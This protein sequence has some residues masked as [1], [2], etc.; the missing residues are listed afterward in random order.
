MTEN[1][2]INEHCAYSYKVS[3]MFDDG[4]H[5]R[6]KI[7]FVLLATEQTIED[8]M[9]TLRPDGVGIHFTRAWI[10]DGITVDT[11]SRH[12]ND[13]AR[14]AST[15]LPDGSLDV[16]CYGCTSGSLV[17]GEERVARELNRGAPKAHATSLI[18]AA[19]A[20]LRALS[21]VR[22]AVATPYLD[23]INDQERIYLEEAGFEVTSIQG[24]QLEKDSDMIRVRPD[25][26]AELARTVDTAE[27]EAVFISCGA[28]RSLDIVD[29]LEQTLGK[30]VICSN[31][32]MMWH[33]LRLVGI[34][35]PI[36]GYGMLLRDL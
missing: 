23:E 1:E 15:L 17:I 19:I 11:L 31:Q 16:I 29:A 35:D 21:V 30:P 7:G 6:A 34:T 14:A 5:T 12:A 33:A 4:R 25:C 2:Q 24:L 28:L 20:A 8:D 10:E 18:A 36:D 22:V 9:F 32:A 13:L 27:A 26:I 3:D